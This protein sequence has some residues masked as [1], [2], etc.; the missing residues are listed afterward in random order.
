MAY[1]PLPIVNPGAESA[2]AA[3]WVTVTNV[4]QQSAPGRSGGFNFGVANGGDWDFYQDVAIP[5]GEYAAVDAGL[6][7]VWYLCYLARSAL[8]Q[9]TTNASLVARSAGGAALKTW[10][11]SITVSGVWQ[12]FEVHDALPPLTRSL[13]VRFYGN[14]VFGGN[15]AVWD[16]LSLALD[17]PVVRV[18]KGHSYL[19]A[20]VPRLDL[21]AI[22]GTEYVVFGPGVATTLGVSK[23]LLYGVIG[24][25]HAMRVTKGQMYLVVGPPI[26]GGGAYPG[27]VV[28][29]AGADRPQN[30]WGPCYDRPE[31]VMEACGDAA[32]PTTTIYPDQPYPRR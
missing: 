9:P 5:V 17:D 1:V 32:R 10:T 6:R 16:D 27:P 8:W 11:F 19:V 7:T 22:K 3:P 20:G 25:T 4:I 31:T 2:I 26:G 12:A 28:P 15:T 30:T 29:C 23:A 18:P 13:R 14:T 24:F 21:H